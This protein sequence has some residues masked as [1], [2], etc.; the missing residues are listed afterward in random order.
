MK[1]HTLTDIPA[2]ILRAAKST[3]KQLRVH[4]IAIF[5]CEIHKAEQPGDLGYGYAPEDAAPLLFHKDLGCIVAYVTHSG[6]VTMA[7]QVDPPAPA[8]SEYRQTL[9]GVLHHAAKNCG[10]LNSADV[11]VLASCE[12][13]RLRQVLVRCGACRFT[14]AA[15]DV[16]HLLRCIDAGGDYVRDVS[17]PTIDPA[18]QAERQ[19]KQ[20]AAPFVQGD[21]VK[22][23]ARP[24]P[25]AEINPDAP[26]TFCGF[27]END[28]SGAFDGNTV[29]SDA[30]PGL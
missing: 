11:A 24:G 30:D 28:C 6:K 16:A 15:Q 13:S 27:D 20:A 29:T 26:R 10:F 12:S 2:H 17:L 5:Y 19:A 4:R 14:C 1:K 22:L 9:E 18:M 3:A 21:G 7:P 23:S 25:I 8:R